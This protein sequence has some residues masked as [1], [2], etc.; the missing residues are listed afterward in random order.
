M[1]VLKSIADRFS[2]AIMVIH[3]T[4]KAPASDPFDMVSGTTGLMGCADSTFVMRKEERLSKA[5]TLDATGRDIE[6]LH[7]DLRFSDETMCW[8]M[9][10]SNLDEQD[11]PKHDS[12]LKLV[13]SFMDTQ[14]MWR[15]TASEL[16]Q[17]LL[18]LQPD[19]DLT[20]NVLVRILNAHTPVV[21]NL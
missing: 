15:G 14:E 1:S 3:H 21:R 6:N 2:I 5:A 9:I 12:I 7:F 11:P 8:E 17:E 10:T 13:R 19:L 4:R 20:A 18:K 16:L